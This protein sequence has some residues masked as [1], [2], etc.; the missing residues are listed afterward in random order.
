M[1]VLDTNIISELMRP[2]PAAAVMAWVNTQPQNTL[3][4]SSVTVAELPAQQHQQKNTIHHSL[5]GKT[6]ALTC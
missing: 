6:D 4:L 3:Y 5:V 1:I 2:R